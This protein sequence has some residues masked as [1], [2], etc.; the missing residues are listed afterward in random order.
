[1]FSKPLLVI[2]YVSVAGQEATTVGDFT[3]WLSSLL[4]L[5]MS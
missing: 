2:L 3:F 5:S 1:M 4:S